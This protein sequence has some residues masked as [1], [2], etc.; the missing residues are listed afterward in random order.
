MRVLRGDVWGWVVITFVTLLNNCYLGIEIETRFWAGRYGEKDKSPK[1]NPLKLKRLNWQEPTMKKEIGKIMRVVVLIMALATAA[2][3]VTMAQDFMGSM[4]PRS[5]T[6]TQEQK[7]KSAKSTQ[8]K[9]TTAAKTKKEKHFDLPDKPNVTDANGLKQGEWGPKYDN[10]QYKY[11][12]T[13]KDGRPVGSVVRYT[14]D[15]KKSM[16]MTY[17]SKSDTCFVLTYHPN[18]KLASRGQYVNQ[19]RE[20]TW[21]LYKADGI[22]VCTEE[23][24]VGKRHGIQTILYE[25]GKTM[26]M[27]TWVDGSQTGPYIKFY[28]GGAKEIET[29]Y[30]YGQ[31]DGHYRSWG[32]DGKLSQEGDYDNGVRVGKWHLRY[33]ELNTE[34]DVVYDKYGRAENQALLDS[35]DNRMIELGEQQIGKYTDPQ[36]FM[37]NPED[38]LPFS[39]Q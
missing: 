22:L 1:T 9:G 11:V 25:D 38:Y 35:L 6:Q 29:N 28:I 24:F 2:S 27:I 14:R 26:E 8:K 32:L 36:D 20:G 15:G 4:G 37:N 10:G 31:L 39:M 17:D 21:K 3:N 34:I 5:K 13:F 12:A 19:K 30:K 23:Y 16:Q 18:G 33:A 7:S